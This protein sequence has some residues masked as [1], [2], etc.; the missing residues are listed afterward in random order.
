[1][2]L[3]K[4]KS[5]LKRKQRF[6]KKEFQIRFIVKFC[7]ILLFGGAIAAG[8]TLFNTNGSLTTTFV[9]SKLLIQN[10]SLAI[11]PSV[12][13]TTLITTGLIGLVVVML[14]LIVSHKIAG[15]MFRF[16]KDIARV[17]KGDL[18]SRINIRKGDQL[19]ELATSLNTMIDHLNTE[20]S[21]ISAD[22]DDIAG[23][24]ENTDLPPGFS[25]DLR[26]LNDKIK[27]RFRL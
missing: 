7:L 21:E 26:G 14:T 17:T 22:I 18:K 12:L 3:K 15:P 13:Y 25:Q 11:L 4:K 27:S 16:E 19:Q 2:N 23:K 20:L 1:M 5:A 10:T 9:N 6:I 8:L 24:A